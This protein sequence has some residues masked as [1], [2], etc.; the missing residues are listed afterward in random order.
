MQQ[1]SVETGNGVEAQSTLLIRLLVN[2]G[3][4][5]G[6][7]ACTEQ[8]LGAMWYQADGVS[9]LGLPGCQQEPRFLPSQ[10]ESLLQSSPFL[11][12]FPLRWSWWEG[13]Q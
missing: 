3:Q 6:A 13:K 10:V 4:V 8:L 9:F 11:L 7:P 5:E 2:R 1:T 12:P